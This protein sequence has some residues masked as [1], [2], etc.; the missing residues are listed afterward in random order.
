MI[1][2]S[3]RV[4]ELG[5]RYLEEGEGPVVLLVHGGTLGF[6]A[7]VWQRNM[8]PLAARG[9]RVIA[10][11]QPGFGFSDDP[12]EFTTGY[13]QDFITRFLDAMGIARA[14]LVGHSQ[15]GG[16]VVHA[17]LH[18]P[19]R[20]RGIVVLGTGSLLPPLEEKAR[21]VE[22]PS[23]EPMLEDTRRLLEENLHRHELITPD[24]LAQYH[25]MCIARN[26][27]NAM[28]RTSAGTAK[29]AAGSR[30][31]WQRLDEVKVPLLLI[32]G[33]NDR[34]S[35]ARRVALARERYPGLRYHLLEDCH[36]IVQW[37]CADEFAGLTA[38]FLR[39]CPMDG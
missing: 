33:K 31:L 12:P 4:D 10:Y 38:E 18:A 9:Y 34:G 24:V 23:R 29:P 39:A 22:P 3:V 5:I 8:A 16:F 2:S 25:R 13:R 26:F 14:A 11:D 7:D 1:E 28:R 17:A 6:S 32:Y 36:H 35:A 19:Q 30:P 37:D 27:T 20:C 15:A 21:D